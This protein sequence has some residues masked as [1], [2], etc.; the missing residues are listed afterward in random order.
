MGQ[1]GVGLSGRTGIV[2]ASPLLRRYERG[3]SGN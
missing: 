1:G 3:T 2:K